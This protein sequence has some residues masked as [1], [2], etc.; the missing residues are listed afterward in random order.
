LF[1]HSHN[2]QETSVFIWGEYSKRNC[3][4]DK[5][6]PKDGEVLREPGYLAVCRE[7]DCFTLG[8]KT[9]RQL[10]IVEIEA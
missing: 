3:P 1:W 8:I 9:L 2:W 7:S 10:K 4:D 5:Y 6:T